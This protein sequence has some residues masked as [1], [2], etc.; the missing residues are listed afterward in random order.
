MPR[1]TWRETHT[2]RTTRGDTFHEYELVVA[3]EGA[4]DWA[5]TVIDCDRPIPRGATERR[6]VRGGHMQTLAQGKRY[7]EEACDEYHATVYGPGAE[8]RRHC[9]VCGEPMTSTIVPG[10]SCGFTS[11][12]ARRWDCQRCQAFW[13]EITT[14][15]EVHA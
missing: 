7:A 8:K 9:N 12:W 14:T 13:H 15:L 10:A 2:K 1:E 3:R 11:E 5:F 4:H 6:P